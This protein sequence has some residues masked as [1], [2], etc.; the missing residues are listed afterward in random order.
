MAAAIC[1]TER[2][3][4]EVLSHSWN[5]VQN[6]KLADTLAG[7]MS[8]TGP[9]RPVATCI[10]IAASVSPAGH[11]LIRALRNQTNTLDETPALSVSKTVS[12]TCT[13]LPVLTE[14]LFPRPGPAAGRLK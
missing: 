13:R 2:L 6:I 5:P 1:L 3:W 12:V 9:L 14:R 8:Y 7:H 10:C 4:T 11:V